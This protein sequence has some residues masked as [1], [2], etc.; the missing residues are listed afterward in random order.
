MFAIT[1]LL[2][3]RSPGSDSQPVSSGLLASLAPKGSKMTPGSAAE[4][5]L[6]KYPGHLDGVV[7]SRTKEDTEN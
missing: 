4:P 6:E 2:D 1:K 3:C 7:S 5:H